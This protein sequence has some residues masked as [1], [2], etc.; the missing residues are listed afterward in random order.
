MV[1]EN[2]TYEHK[3]IQEAALVDCQQ[4]IHELKNTLHELE[5]VET[6]YFQCKDDK[7]Q[8]Q[9]E[10]NQIQYQLINNGTIDGSNE[11]QRKA[12]KW[13]HTKK[14]QA[15]KRQIENEE[16]KLKAKYNHLQ[17]KLS[18]LQ[19]IANITISDKNQAKFIMLTFK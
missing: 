17:R 1:R 4:I 13:S 7:Q 5:K 10:I 16:Q 11:D 6:Q 19:T 15:K 3:I 12:Q 2:Y 8:I 18:T 14:L 9:H